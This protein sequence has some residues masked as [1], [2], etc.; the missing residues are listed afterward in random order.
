VGLSLAYFTYSHG[1]LLT[2]RSVFYP[3]LG[4]K[5]YGKRGD[6][7]DIFAVLATLFGLATSL[8]LGVQQIAAGLSHV[9]GL[10]SG[11]ITQVSLIAIITALSPQF[12]L[13]W[14]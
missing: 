8:R 6:L 2:I 10:D 12:L 3:V 5:I 11:I 14:A 13:C 4:D 7:I 1:L 9:F